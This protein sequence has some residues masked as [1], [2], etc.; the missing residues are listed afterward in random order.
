MK[1]EPK[2]LANEAGKFDGTKHP[3]HTRQNYDATATDNEGERRS[4]VALRSESNGHGNF[5]RHIDPCISEPWIAQRLKNT[6]QCVL[7]L[8][9]YHLLRSL[10]EPNSWKDAAPLTIENPYNNEGE[11]A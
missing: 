3:P 5:G 9:D 10:Y 6:T 7:A 1:T 4:L 11:T 2:P 8:P